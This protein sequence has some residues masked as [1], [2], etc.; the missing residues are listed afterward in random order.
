MYGVRYRGANLRPGDKVPV[1]AALTLVVGGHAEVA[2]SDSLD[3]DMN[4]NGNTPAEADAPAREDES[5][6]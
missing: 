6:F 1:G 5:W 3:V 2:V 4:E